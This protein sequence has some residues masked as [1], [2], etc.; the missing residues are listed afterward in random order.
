VFFVG[1]VKDGKIHLKRPGAFEAFLAS[2][3][4]GKT[5]RI[6]VNE[7]DKHSDQQRRWFHWVCAFVAKH[8]GDHTPAEVKAVAKFRTL[9][10]RFDERGEP[11]MGQSRN[12]TR[13]EYSLLIDGLIQFAAEELH[14]VVPDPRKP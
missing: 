10:F 14:L 13:E 9:P 12:C 1:V 4:N 6:E 2:I 11:H 8:C 5:V 7:W 3:K